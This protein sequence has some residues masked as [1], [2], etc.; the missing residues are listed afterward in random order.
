MKKIKNLFKR[1][2]KG[3]R[4]VYNDVE[5]SSQWVV[6]GEGTAT[7]KWDGTS[8][9]IQDGQLYKRYDA[10]HGKKIP[11][12]FIPC[13]DAPDPVSGHFPGWV[14]VDLKAP[15]D[16]WH[17]EAWALG[18]QGL[19]DG[20]YELVGPKVQGNAEG[21][22]GFHRFHRHGDALLDG[23][24]RTFDELGAYLWTHP[25]MEG[26][27]WHHPDGRMVKAKRKDFPAPSSK[28]L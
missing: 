6:D 24:P 15:G 26:V 19:P 12:N 18:G 11:P 3:L 21:L 22:L 23:V 25:D 17:A 16:R 14:P 20:T 1:E 4:H 13:E 2:P 7:R 9:L 8:C 5:P 27:V 28:D 10:K